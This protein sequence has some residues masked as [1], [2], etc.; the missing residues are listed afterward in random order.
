MLLNGQPLDLTN[1]NL[2][3]VLDQ[4][5]AEA[6]P[7]CLARCCPKWLLSACSFNN[8]LP[9]C[10]DAQAALAHHSQQQDAEC[11]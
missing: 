1:F 5:A 3:A 8:Q 10:V 9:A 11:C 4:L 7:A 2:Y 6:S